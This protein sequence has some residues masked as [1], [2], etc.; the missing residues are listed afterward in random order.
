MCIHNNRIEYDDGRSEPWET[1]RFLR[2][3]KVTA[4]DL[5]ENAMGQMSTIMMRR[6]V[7]DDLRAWNG[8]LSEWVLSDWFIGIVACRLGPI[9]YIDRTMSAFRQHADNAFSLLTRAAQWAGF[10][11]NYEMAAKV[12]GESHQAAIEKAICVRSYLAAIEYEKERDFG[13]AGK[14]LARALEGR[15]EWLEP[16][17]AGYGLSGEELFR[18]SARRLWLYR[19]PPLFRFWSL[20]AALRGVLQRRWLDISL[21]VRAHVRLRRREAIGFI[22]ASPNPLIASPKAPD[23]AAV[24]L[25]WVSAAAAATEVRLG[26]PDGR[27]LSRG[28]YE[29]QRTTGEW[30]A[31]GMLF[32]L[33]NVTG[34]RPL[35]LENTLDVVRIGVKR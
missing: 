12:L 6:Q 15:P 30:V 2:R 7:A 24:T 34:G 33:Q 27:L 31:D 20:F 4:E 19:F 1:V 8:V 14:F 28:G 9:A 26:R 11:H 32:Y 13:D 21:R 35:T 10:V 18:L 16:F 29:G 17:C 25:T 3:E 23:R 5:L 22:T